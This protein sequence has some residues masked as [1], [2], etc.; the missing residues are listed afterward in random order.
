ME[1]AKDILLKFLGGF[2]VLFLLW[3]F[4]GGPARWEAKIAAEQESQNNLEI[5]G[6]EIPVDKNY[7]FLKS[8][9]TIED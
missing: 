5:Q 6:E 8:P 1:D 2:G 7:L 9:A 3:I 4:M